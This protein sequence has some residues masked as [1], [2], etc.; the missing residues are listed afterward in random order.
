MSN[1]AK[2]VMKNAKHLEIRD[3]NGNVRVKTEKG[4]GEILM[5]LAEVLKAI[6]GLIFRK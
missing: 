4:D 6:A 3:K 5:G 2:E 1:L